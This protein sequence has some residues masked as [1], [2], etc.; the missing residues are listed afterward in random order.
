MWFHFTHILANAASNTYYHSM[1]DAI[2]RVNQG[3]DPLHTRAIYGELLNKNREELQ[4]LIASYKN[5]WL[6]HGVTLGLVVGLV[7]PDQAL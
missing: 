3:I 7:Q 5:K 1:I 4:T 6:R 2:Y